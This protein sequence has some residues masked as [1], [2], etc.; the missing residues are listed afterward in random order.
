MNSID[1]CDHL[2]VSFVR[3]C[4]LLLVTLLD[5][6]IFIVGGVNFLYVCIL[7]QLRELV[8]LGECVSLVHVYSLSSRVCFI[9][10]CVLCFLWLVVTH[11][12]PMWTL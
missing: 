12:L 9:L 5:L 7:C 1:G 3:S 6:C 8:F 2:C 11:Q 10:F 4:V